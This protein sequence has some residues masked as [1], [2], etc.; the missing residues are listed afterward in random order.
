LIKGGTSGAE[1]GVRI[2]ER[3]ILPATGGFA[4]EPSGEREGVEKRNTKLGT[5]AGD[6]VWLNKCRKDLNCSDL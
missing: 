4:E 2:I 3:K 5:F 1:G 6:M